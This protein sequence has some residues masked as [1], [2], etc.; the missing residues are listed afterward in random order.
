MKYSVLDACRIRRW[1]FPILL[2]RSHFR[3]GR[4]LVVTHVTRFQPV[5]VIAS[6][7]GLVKEK[8]EIT[9]L[10]RPQFLPDKNYS[11]VLNASSARDGSANDMALCR[12]IDSRFLDEEFLLG[13]ARPGVESARSIELTRT[14]TLSDLL[15]APLDCP[16]PESIE[17]FGQR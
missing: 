8:L 3:K 1:R 2:K 5:I 6:Y 17:D 9:E 16:S 10:P 13:D 4:A 15:S 7:I 12:K 11:F 14:I